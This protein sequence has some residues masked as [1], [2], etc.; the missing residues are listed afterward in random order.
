MVSLLKNERTETLV[1]EECGADASKKHFHLGTKRTAGAGKREYN[2]T[3]SVKRA[4]LDAD[5]V[6]ELY[7]GI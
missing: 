5:F 4:A 1:C 6:V 3:P 2:F 7:R